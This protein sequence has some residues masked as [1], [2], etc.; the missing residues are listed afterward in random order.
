M[1]ARRLAIQY[2]QQLEEAY[3]SGREEALKSALS[4]LLARKGDPGETM[5]RLRHLEQTSNASGVPALIDE[6]GDFLAAA[7]EHA[8]IEMK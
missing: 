3:A 8:N 5:G 6:M 2:I 1:D 4:S 7:K